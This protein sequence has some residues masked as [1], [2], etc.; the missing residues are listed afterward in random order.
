MLEIVWRLVGVVTHSSFTASALLIALAASGPDNTANLAQTLDRLLKKNQQ[1]R[2]NNQRLMGKVVSFRNTAVTSCIP[3]DQIRTVDH[4]TAKNER[5]L[6]KNQEVI[7]ESV[8]VL[9]NL[10]KRRKTISEEKTGTTKKIIAWLFH[11]FGG[12]G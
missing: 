10:V 1:L 11:L 3:I 5:L 6:K 9:N 12:L 7:T 8:M 4:L 2:N